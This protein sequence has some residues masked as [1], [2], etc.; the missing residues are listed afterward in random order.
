[1]RGILLSPSLFSFLFLLFPLWVWRRWDSF[2]LFFCFL[3][4]RATLYFV[5]LMI[6]IALGIAHKYLLKGNSP[7]RRALRPVQFPSRFSLRSLT[8]TQTKHARKN[9]ITI[10]SHRASPNHGSLSSPDPNTH[11]HQHYDIINVHNDFSTDYH[12]FF[13]DN[14]TGNNW[15]ANNDYHHGNTRNNCYFYRRR[16]RGREHHRRR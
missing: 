4:K 6:A 16:G 7:Q 5:Y 15:Q 13:L 10:N 3:H 11:Y 2:F 9:G 1:M 14:Q 12:L 8:K